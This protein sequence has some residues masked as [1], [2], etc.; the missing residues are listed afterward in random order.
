MKRALWLVI[1]LILLIA[2][3]GCG[4]DSM[5]TAPAN[6]PRLAAHALRRALCLAR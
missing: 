5:P 2:L 4:E 3:A 1:P 6:C